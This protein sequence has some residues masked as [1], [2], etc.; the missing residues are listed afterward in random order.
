MAQ[1]KL[2][3]VNKVLVNLRESVVGTTSGSY[4]S[5]I[6]EFVNQAKEKVEDA[7]PWRTLAVDITFTTILGQRSYDL[8]QAGTTPVITTSPTQ[9]YLTE[10]STLVYDDETGEPSA[11]LTTVS[12]GPLVEAQYE[13][14]L[15]ESSYEVLAVP[16]TAPSEFAYTFVGTVPTV[17][18]RNPPD[19]AYG[20][21][22]R[23]T[24]PQDEL[25][26]DATNLLVPY[27]PVVSYAT[28][29]AMAE[30]GEELGPGALNYGAIGDSELTRA[31]TNDQNRTIQVRAD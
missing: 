5:L 6:S 12:P 31:I 21:R 18:F 29:L 22:F 2:Q 23:F 7:W 25:T 30:R 20:V 19:G 10:R 4:A 17:V 3:L 26:N 1:T 15:R 27:R 8:S 13:A 24:V 16:N 28:A 9:R 11:F 14:M